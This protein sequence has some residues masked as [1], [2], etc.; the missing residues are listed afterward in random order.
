MVIKVV[1]RTNGEEEPA[2]VVM[3]FDSA[4]SGSHPLY[5]ARREAPHWSEH[6]LGRVW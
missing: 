4:M 3:H 2:E 1:A 6:R 5:Q